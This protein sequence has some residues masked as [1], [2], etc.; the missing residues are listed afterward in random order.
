MKSVAHTPGCAI[1]WALLLIRYLWSLGEPV[2]ACE[3]TLKKQFPSPLMGILVSGQ[4]FGI[5]SVVVSVFRS[6]SLPAG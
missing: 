3:I 2:R 1:V 4:V 6:A 5:L